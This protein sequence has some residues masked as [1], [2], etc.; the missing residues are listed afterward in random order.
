MITRLFFKGLTKEKR[1]SG[2]TRRQML[3]KIENAVKRNI[4][5]TI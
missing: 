5:K 1:F 3:V 2:L 4:E